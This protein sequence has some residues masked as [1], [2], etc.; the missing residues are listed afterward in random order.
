MRQHQ[1]LKIIGSATAFALV[2]LLGMLI[3]SRHGQASQDARSVSEYSILSALFGL[4]L[5]GGM[6]QVCA[7]Q[8]LTG[9]TFL[10]KIS[11]CRRT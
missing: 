2:I 10:N 1:F 9:L 5:T 11:S 7:W 8:K 6:W 3:T 4:K